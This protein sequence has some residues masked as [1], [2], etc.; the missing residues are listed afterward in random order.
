MAEKKIF[1]ILGKSASGKD[2]I[3]QKICQECKLNPIVYYTTRPRRSGEINGKDYFYVSDKYISDAE[4]DGTLIEK[5]IYNTVKGLW[6]YATINDGQFDTDTDS[7]IVLPPKGYES[8]VKY[9]GE[10]RVVPIFIHVPDGIR[11]RRSIERDE[12]QE[13][14]NYLETCRRFLADAEDFK[15]LA[16]DANHTFENDEIELCVENIIRTMGF[17]KNNTP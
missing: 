6:T 8:F 9:F 4:K 2:T 10:S 15:N 11:L 14:P 1:I 17:E 3:F 5:R 7:I 12:K 16:I 13:V